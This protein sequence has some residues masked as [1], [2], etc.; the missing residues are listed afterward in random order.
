ME[1]DDF[2]SRLNRS[3]NLKVAELQRNERLRHVIF[4]SQ[5]DPEL[6]DYLGTVAD[7]IRQFSKSR[8]GRR[9]LGS[10]LSHHRAMLY[11]TQ[12]STRTFLSFTAACQMLGIA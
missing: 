9:F 12:P 11:F 4:S 7:M 5:F 2:E 1:F 8:D 10:L 3:L 6:I